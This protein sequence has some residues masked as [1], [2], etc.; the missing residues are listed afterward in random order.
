MSKLITLLQQYGVILV[1]A[2]V[3]VEQLGI[4]V[5]AFPILIV[6]GALAA[7]GELPWHWCLIA[8]LAA[9]L[10]SDTLWYNAGRRYG[11]RIL[12]LLCKIS[13]SPDYCV[14]QTED[15]FLRWGPKSLLFSKFI[16]GFG[17]IAPPLAGAMGTRRIVFSAYTLGGAI[18]WAGTGI[19]VGAIF[20]PSIDA[21][22]DT[23]STMGTTALIIIAAIVGLI[24]LVKYYERRRFYRSLRMARITVHELRELMDLGDEPLIVDARSETAQQM[25]PPIPGAILYKRTDPH[26]SFKDIPRDRPIIVYC[27]CPNEA[28][29]AAIAKQLVALGFKQVRPLVGGLDAWN[30][31][32]ETQEAA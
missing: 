25:Q 18:L 16:P 29:A 4:P 1:F 7:R 24:M 11:K 14:S 2:N 31:A 20:A 22:L 5:P 26:V 15:T 28:S 30:D 19:G 9:C 32:F 27:S 12:R 13:L 6:S 21:V 3:L 17:T 10:T 8:A 23:L